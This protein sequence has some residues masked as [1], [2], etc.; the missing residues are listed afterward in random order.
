MTVVAVGMVGIALQPSLG[1]DPRRLEETLHP[2][3]PGGF[4]RTRGRPNQPRFW[5]AA[6]SV[7]SLRRLVNFGPIDRVNSEF[8][9]HS[10]ISLILDIVRLIYRLS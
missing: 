6:S 7:A 3:A 2:T 9:A 10:Y 1:S 5:L 4:G 8:L